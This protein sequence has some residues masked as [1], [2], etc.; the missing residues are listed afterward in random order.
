MSSN[1]TIP[2]KLKFIF[3]KYILTQHFQKF[4]NYLSDEHFSFLLISIFKFISCRDLNKGFV[5]FK[6]DKCN[7]T[8][9]FPI[10]CKSRLCPSCGYKYSQSW[11]NK[12]SNNILNIPHRHVLFTIPKQCREFFFYDRSLLSSLSHAVNDIFKYQFHNINKKNMRNNKISKYSK[13]YF[14]NSDIVHYGLISVIHTFGRDLKWNPHIHAIVSLGGF[15]KHFKYK[16]NKY[17]HVNTIS[18]QWRFHVL[19]AVANGHYPNSKIKHKAKKVVSSLYKKDVRLFFNVGHDEL[20][21]TKGIIKYLGRYLARAPIAEYKI[22]HIDNDSVSF[23]YH[24]LSNNKE[25]TF[26][27]MPLFQFASKVL[28]HFPPKNFKMIHRYGFYA[29]RKSKKLIATINLFKKKLSKYEPSF[30]VKSIFKTFGLNPFYCPK[31]NIK[32][33]IFEF[34]LYYFPAPRKYQ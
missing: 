11:A 23:F 26:I 19:N 3:S 32:M 8:H 15:N 2:S 27:S 4:K 34:Y 25:K 7:N 5:S 16:K 33:K 29:R 21:N 14:T 12:T 17:F 22:S 13:K 28:I 24:D 31:C 30:Y 1:P 18:K 9:K 20:N 6:C 10:T